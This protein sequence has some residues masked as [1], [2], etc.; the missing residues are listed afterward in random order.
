MPLVT[1]GVEH[2]NL[3]ELALARMRD[4]G[5]QV[6]RI[7]LADACTLSVTIICQCIYNS[8]WSLSCTTSFDVYLKILHESYFVAL[9]ICTLLMIAV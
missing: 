4:L 9:L 1:S 8:L 3:R 5:T 2:G 7:Y 6:Q